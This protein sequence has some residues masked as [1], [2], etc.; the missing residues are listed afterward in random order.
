MFSDYSLCQIYNDTRYYFCCLTWLLFTLWFD[1]ESR[2]FLYTQ[3]SRYFC[4][5]TNPRLQVVSKIVSNL[6]LCTQ[7]E[8]TIP[9]SNFKNI[10]PISD[11]IAVLS[12]SE[13]DSDV[14]KAMKEITEFTVLLSHTQYIH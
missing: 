4:Y 12:L 2:G 3:K 9:S 6:I 11:I 7:P 14:I 10:A 13:F 1:N 5:Q 8:L